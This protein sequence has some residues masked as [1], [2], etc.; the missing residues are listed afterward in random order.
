MARRTDLKG[1]EK[2]LYDE[3]YDEGREDGYLAGERDGKAVGFWEGYNEAV[4]DLKSLGVIDGK[5]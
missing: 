2:Q 5:E 1:P 3:A 4:E